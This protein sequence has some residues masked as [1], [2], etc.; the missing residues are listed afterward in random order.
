MAGSV[1]SVELKERNVSFF[2]L[3]LLP[4]FFSTKELWNSYF[5][6]CGDE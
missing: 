3:L 6:F 4:S 5:A 2:L 1:N